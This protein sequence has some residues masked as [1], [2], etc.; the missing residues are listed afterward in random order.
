[1][2]PIGIHRSLFV[3]PIIETV[4]IFKATGLPLS[5]VAREIRVET[6]TPT[7]VV[8]WDDLETAEVEEFQKQKKGG[9]ADEIETSIQL[10]LQPNLVKMELAKTDYGSAPTKTYPGYKPGLFSKNS[11]DPAFSKTG[12]FGD[13]TLAT[14]EKGKKALEIMTKQWLK[15]LKE[16]SKEPLRK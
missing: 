2:F 7:L 13:P 3:G 1:M 4:G 14:A 10:F 16:F 12:L 6:G 11:K 9:H 8:S 5:I 15:A